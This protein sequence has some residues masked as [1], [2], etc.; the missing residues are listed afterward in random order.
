M[1]TFPPRLRCALNLAH[2]A[3]FPSGVNRIAVEKA[4]LDGLA[5]LHRLLARLNEPAAS[6]S[7]LSTL[8]DGIP[9]LAARLHARFQSMR[10]RDETTSSILSLLGNRVLE[11]MLMDLLEDLTV[12]HADLADDGP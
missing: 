3:S 8:V 9:V 11:G 10:G 12:L 5:A 6:A 4:D 2:R 1:C 7:A